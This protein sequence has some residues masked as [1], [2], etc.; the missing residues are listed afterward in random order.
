[1]DAA[2]AAPPAQ[3]APPA[4]ASPPARAAT[5]SRENTRARLLD[6][7]ALVFAEA[8]VD[9][10]SV[11]M[12]AERAGFTRGAFYSNFGSKHEL[13]LALVQRVTEAKLDEIGRRLAALESVPAPGATPRTPS[14]LVRYIVDEDDPAETM[15]MGE[16]RLQAMR[17]T[18]LAAS[19]LE[20]ES[21]L[22]ARIVQIVHEAALIGGISLRIDAE[23]AAR[24]LLDL[25]Q[26]SAE[27]AAITARSPA[28][29]HRAFLARI[30]AVADLFTS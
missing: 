12:I 4:H 10:T 18:A 15:L 16:I 7:A 20:W 14:D 11:E 24:M 26:A 6:A 5:R 29:S 22:V 25:G 19:Y 2:H 17:D 30:A 28:E 21:D 1:M 23:V 8:G 13:L 27:R 3:D 9:A